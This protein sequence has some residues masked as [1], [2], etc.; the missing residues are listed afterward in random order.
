MNITHTVTERFLRYVKID[1][2]SDPASP[3]CPSTEKQKDLGRVLV[4]ELLAMGIADAHL[5]EHGYVYATIPSNTDKKVPVICFCSHMDTSPDCSGK[6]VKPQLH[7]KYDGKDIILPGDPAQIIRT[8]E[9]PELL[10][11]TGNDIITTDGTTLLGADNKAGLAEIMD[12]AHFLITHPEV[13]HGTIRILFTPDEEIGRGVDK[14]DMKKLGADFGYTMDG[15][16]AGHLEDETFSADG[17]TI[18]ITGV[19]THPG[20]AKGKMENALKIGARILEKLPQDTCSP[21]TTEKKEGFLHPTGFSGTLEKATLSFIVRDFDDAGLKSKEELLEKT[22]KEVMKNFPRSS[23]KL[24]IKEQYRN[25]K[26]VLDKYPQVVDYA[27]DAIRAAGLEPVRSSIRGGTDG[28]RLSFMG[29]PCPNIFAGEH[30][31]HSRHEW[32]SVQD[33]EKAVLTIIH[34]CRIWEERS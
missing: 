33:M 7:K 22:V 25:M 23:Y 13:K 29:L 31:F 16:S 17:A 20:F 27:L 30:A 3:T 19:S 14:A 26:V 34:L 18:E 12:A 4:E 8:A 6:N 15:E 32:V 11:Q 24:E 28:S 2:Q 9:H 1:T 5:D 10:K 21:E